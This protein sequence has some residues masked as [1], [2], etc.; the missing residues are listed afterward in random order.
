[1]TWTFFPKEELPLAV[2]LESSCPKAIFIRSCLLKL[3]RCR[4][5]YVPTLSSPDSPTYDDR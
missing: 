2:A 4:M 5:P 1:M 3:R